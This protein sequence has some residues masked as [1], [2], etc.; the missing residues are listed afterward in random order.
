MYVFY[1]LLLK[2]SFLREWGRDVKKVG[3]LGLIKIEE[4][5]STN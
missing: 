5:W 3:V 2:V 1:Y 4:E